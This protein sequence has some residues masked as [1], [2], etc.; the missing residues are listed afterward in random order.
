MKEYFIFNKVSSALK[1]LNIG[2]INPQDICNYYYKKNK[3]KPFEYIY[4]E[5]S[6]KHYKRGDELNNFVIS[7]C[8]FYYSKRFIDGFDDSVEVFLYLINAYITGLYDLWV[9]DF[10]KSQNYPYYGDIKDFKKDYLKYISYC[11]LNRMFFNYE[12]FLKYS[13]KEYEKLYAFYKDITES[14]DVSLEYSVCAY[15]YKR[16]K[17]LFKQLIKD[18][19]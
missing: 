9:L 16:R 14:K 1:A 2:N 18:K 11:L 5:I 10:F 19:K 4:E 15:N 3:E 8:I 13:H 17:E 7:Y 12:S 6:K